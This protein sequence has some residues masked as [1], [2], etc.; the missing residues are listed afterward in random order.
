MLWLQWQRAT[1]SSGTSD[2]C[3]LVLQATKVVKEIQISLWGNVYVEEIYHLV[4]YRNIQ[5]GNQEDCC[6]D[7]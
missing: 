1:K 4:G 5:N 2:I 6:A 3:F 7:V